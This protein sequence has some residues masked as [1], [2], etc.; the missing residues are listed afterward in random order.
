MKP[1]DERPLT[2][3]ELLRALAGGALVCAVIAVI[4]GFASGR[5]G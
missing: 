3:A 5:L 1:Y 4:Y 2:T